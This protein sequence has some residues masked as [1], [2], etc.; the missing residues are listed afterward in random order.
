MHTKNERSKR[1]TLTE[2]D[3][4]MEAEEENRTCGVGSRGLSDKL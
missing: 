2:G 1:A 4:T 3:M